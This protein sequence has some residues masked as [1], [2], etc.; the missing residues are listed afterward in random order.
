MIVI[1]MVYDE[2]ENSQIHNIFKWL[3]GNKMQSVAK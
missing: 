2:S 3:G 1:G